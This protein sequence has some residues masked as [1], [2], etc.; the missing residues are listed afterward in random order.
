LV[1]LKTRAEM[2]AMARGGAIIGDLYLEMR[3]RI[4]PGVSTGELDRFAEEFIRSHEGAIPAFKGLYG[5]PGSV[6]AS[7]N[8]EVV[9]GI[10]SDE[11]VLRDGDILSLDTG[12]KLDGWCSDSAWTFPVGEVDPKVAE[13]LRVTRL[14]LE[15]AIE[16]AVPGNHVGDIGHAVEATVKS[17]GFRIVRD[18]VGH[19]IGRKV[20]EDPQ[21]PNMGQPGQGPPLLEGMTLAIEP[22][23]SAGTWRIR[24]QADRWTM[25]ITDGSPSAHY[26]HTVGVTAD[27]PRILTAASQGSASG[28]P[29]TQDAAR[30]TS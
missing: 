11:R 2:D 8:E 26:E 4:R 6:C 12:V 23:I 1:E 29:D 28:A 15:R 14:A 20:H 10:P 25:V 5:F 21:V 22:M 16:A 30:P 24:T 13:L 9:H 3:S 7:L 27:G 17:T 19:G 18:L